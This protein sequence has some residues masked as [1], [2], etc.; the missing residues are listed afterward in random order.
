MRDAV[1]YDMDGTLADVTGIRHH[2]TGGNTDFH[3]FHMGSVDVPANEDVV[4]M[5][6][7][8]QD[9]GKAILIVTARN[10][11]YMH[12]TVWWLLFAGITYDQ[13]YMRA[14]DDMRPDWEVKRDILAMIRKDGF[15]PVK[16]VDDNPHVVELW[17]S[18]N[19]PTVI[20]PGWVE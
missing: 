12:V 15:N 10:A 14:A 2:V 16:A 7:K 20:V 11:K 18:E 3:A 5:L 9:E 8:D 19:I 13:M 4:D 17:E 1:I 6:Y